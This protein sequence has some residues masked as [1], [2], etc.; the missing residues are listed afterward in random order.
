MT[1]FPHL[2]PEVAQMLQAPPPERIEFCREDRWVAYPVA[3]DAVSRLDDLLSHPRS[4][5][6]PN[7]LIVARSGNGKSSI[8]EHFTNRHEASVDAGGYPTVPVLLVEVPPDPTVSSFCSAILWKLNDA[9]RE[10]DS[11]AMKLRQVKSILRHLHV[12]MLVLD[13]FNNIAEAGRETRAL[14]STVRSLAND[15]KI[16]ICAAGTQSA[17]NALNQDPQLKSRFEPFGLPAWKLDRSYLGFLASYEK[18][19]PLAKPSG[20][21]GKELAPLLKSLC[22]EA[23]GETVKLLKMAAAHAI[24]TGDERITPELLTGLPWVA[25]AKWSDVAKAI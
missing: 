4:L 19:L 3:R 20:L 9:H 18:L 15:L 14:L 7:L 13:E 25:P 5:R 6:M 23:I 8:L 21:A 17:V 2:A 1:K 22:G 12:R 10:K 24:R 16:V 11:T